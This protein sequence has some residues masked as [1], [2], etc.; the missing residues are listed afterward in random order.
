METVNALGIGE[1][2]IAL[3][4]SN[5]ID[6]SAI[7]NRELLSGLAVVDV[8]TPDLRNHTIHSLHA[9][10]EQVSNPAGCEF[11]RSLGG[12]FAASV[13]EAAVCCAGQIVAV[14][15]TA[16]GVNI[17]RHAA[18]IIACTADAADI[19]AVD[20]TGVVANIARHAADIIT[21]AAN[22]AGVVA[23]ADCTLAGNI[24]RHAADIIFT[25][26]VGI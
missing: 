23:V 21:C 22:G 25:A 2:Y 16:V 17:A 4:I 3:A 14:A 20:D 8:L 10:L 26:E 13:A 11:F 6:R 1:M 9:G 12:G 7:Q 19:V 5:G 18:N 15:D 24:S